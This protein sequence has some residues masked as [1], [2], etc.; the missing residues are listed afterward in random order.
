M[1]TRNSFGQGEAWYVASSPDKSFL[2]DFAAM[3]VKQAGIESVLAAPEGIE[4][5]RRVKDGQAYTMILN[6]NDSETEVNLGSNQRTELL[7]GQA[8]SGAVKIP[9]KGVWILEESSQ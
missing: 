3:L 5:T 7:D 6:H 1:L 4:A 2:A 9:A 8:V